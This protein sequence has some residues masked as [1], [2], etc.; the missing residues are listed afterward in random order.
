MKSVIIIVILVVGAIVAIVP[1]ILMTYVPTE[2]MDSDIN[3]KMHSLSD[4][5][6][7][8]QNKLEKV[9]QAIEQIE[10]ANPEL[11]QIN[12]FTLCIYDSNKGSQYYRDMYTND[13]KY[14]E[15]FD[16]RFLDTTIKQVLDNIEDRKQYYEKLGKVCG[17]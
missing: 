7:G 1:G 16:N 12:D 3:N 15:W 17:N 4:T 10:N 13:P 5:Y 2:R 11:K 14:K 8:M 6:S 9:N